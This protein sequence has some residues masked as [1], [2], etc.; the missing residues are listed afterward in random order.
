M[1]LL[2]TPKYTG[3]LRNRK[4]A[5]LQRDLDDCMLENMWE[6]RKGVYGITPLFSSSFMDFHYH[7]CALLSEHTRT[8]TFVHGYMQDSLSHLYIENAIKRALHFTQ[9]QQQQLVIWWGQQPTTSTQTYIAICLRTFSST[10][11]LSFCAIKLT[12]MGIAWPFKMNNSNNKIPTFKALP[13]LL[14]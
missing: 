6:R 8:H 4:Q 9:Q 7:L 12:Y 3:F 14:L 11:F 1:L 2:L 5:P 10:P 13:F